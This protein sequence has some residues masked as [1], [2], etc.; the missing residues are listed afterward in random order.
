MTFQE[1]IKKD[2]EIFNFIKDEI[3]DG[4]WYWDIENPSNEWVSPNFWTTLGYD[5]NEMPY[6][7]EMW[8]N[9]MHPD[10]LEMSKKLL[11]K[12]FADLS[13]PYMQTVRYFHKNGNIV[14]IRCKAQAFNDENGKLKRMIGAH[15]VETTIVFNN[16]SNEQRNENW[17]NKYSLISTLKQDELKFEKIKDQELS[18]INDINFGA[19]Y[20]LDKEVLKQINFNDKSKNRPSKLVSYLYVNSYTSKKVSSILK[21]INKKSELENQIKNRD[22]LLSYFAANSSDGLVV[23]NKNLEAIFISDSIERYTGV[24]F[25]KYPVSVIDA[26]QFIHEDD[27]AFLLKETLQSIDQ[28]KSNLDIEYR[29]KSPDNVTSWIESKANF[30]YDENNELDKIY[31]V[32]RDITTY[33]K[34]QEDLKIAAKR[35]L[36]VAELLFEEK[37]KSKEKLYK[38][39]HD[40]VNQLLFAASLNIENSG[41]KHEKLTTA[42]T[43]L[44][45]GIEHIREIA[46]ESTFQ[47]IYTDYFFSTLIDY[48]LKVNSNS[49][50]QFN[51]ECDIEEPLKFDDSIKK[52][53]FRII[54]QLVIYAKSQTNET[55]IKI[56]IKKNQNKILMIIVDNSQFENEF[57]EKQ[58]NLIC[59][60]VSFPKPIP[61]ILS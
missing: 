56:R 16:D 45:T 22:N 15:F 52:Q 47:F 32:A 25:D 38:E 44:R 57:Y 29:A 5:P 12:H 34:L 54:Q 39:L 43:N 1:L 3:F 27:R 9:I 23:F 53:V 55:K 58:E 2:P 33:K 50:V 46:V 18:I 42:L 6:N 31:V 37:E 11:E 51:I 48:I 30:E 59:L 10:D 35:R 24:K 19:N 26:F 61:S 14:W 41:L 8:Q 17:S 28:K 7:P 40:G 36:E 60:S 13:I 4:L 49:K 21:P 20:K